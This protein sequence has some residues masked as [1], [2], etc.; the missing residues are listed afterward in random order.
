[1]WSRNRPK[2]RIRLGDVDV[3]WGGKVSS[4]SKA[5]VRDQLWG[6]QNGTSCTRCGRRVAQPWINLLNLGTASTR[7]ELTRSVTHSGGSWPYCVCSL[8]SR[9]PYLR[10]RVNPMSRL[11]IKEYGLE[12]FTVFRYELLE[13]PVD[14]YICAAPIVVRP[15]S[16]VPVILTDHCELRIKRDAYT[17]VTRKL[18]SRPV[19]ECSHN[20]PVSRQHANNLDEGHTYQV[21]DGG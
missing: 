13:R 11:G 3:H 12:E 21:G 1:M 20:Y 5:Q 6:S 14:A 8:T 2:A 18:E 19:V 7:W 9:T 16:T 17:S 10:H 4:A 15:H